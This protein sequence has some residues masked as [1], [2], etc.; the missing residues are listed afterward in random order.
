[1]TD[2][3]GAE[4]RVRCSAT[5]WARF[6]STTEVIERV[7]EV[8]RVARENGTGRDIVRTGSKR[9]KS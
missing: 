6:A 3:E 8:P 4:E 5:N 1:M 7:G 9:L 2:E